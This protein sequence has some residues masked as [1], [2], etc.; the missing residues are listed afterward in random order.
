[1]EAETCQRDPIISA[2]N[3]A[4]TPRTSHSFIHFIIGRLNI[5]VCAAF[6]TRRRVRCT[7]R[8]RLISDVQSNPDFISYTL[9][10]GPFVQIKLTTSKDFY[11]SYFTASL[12]ID[13]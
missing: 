4:V 12:F 3:I 7:S 5:L 2:G 6:Q 11:F 10:Y 9:R 1:M 13:F 8:L